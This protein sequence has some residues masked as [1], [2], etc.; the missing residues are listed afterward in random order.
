MVSHEPD[1]AGQFRLH[2]ARLRD[3]P[4]THGANFLYYAREKI[5]S[6][7]SETPDTNI[8]VWL[9]SPMG[10]AI[11]C[12]PALRAV[13]ERFK[14]SRI[15]FLAN[16]VV[17]E[18]LSPGVFNDEWIEHEEKD[19]L[20]ISRLLRRHRFS[21][22]I[23]FKNSFASALAALLA[24]IPSRIGYA[25]EKRGFLL[26]DRLQAPKLTSGRFEPRSM[27]DYYLAVASWLG[28]E[29]TNRSLELPVAPGA[30]DSIRSRLPELAGTGGPVVV[31]V[32]GGAFGASK[33]WP[34]ERFAQIADRLI[35]DHNA[36]VVISVAP[37]P[38]EKQIAQNICDS[39]EHT[40]INLGEN[41]LSIGELKDLFSVADL[42]ITND[43]GPRHIAIALRRK[44]ITLFGPND[45]AWT[46]TGY[47]NETQ[48]I[49]NVPCAPC[50]RPDCVKSRHICMQAI[51]VDMVC[52]AAKELLEGGR[53]HRI[54]A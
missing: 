36:T 31:L 26:T 20:A 7:Q 50:S 42:V 21:H 5:I 24:G 13:R 12:T 18:I 17:R 46:E 41:P 37:E 33:C 30:G 25:R 44:V 10:D 8:L 2:S 48:I 53:G 29:T 11:L 32:P 47:E 45:P 43:T 35:T 38:A 52:N 54:L 15:T 28:A 34:S 27:I 9:P 39:S 6:V 4:P 1:Q 49:G 40:L 22:A 23:L 3:R 51:T 19:P 16:P 14:S